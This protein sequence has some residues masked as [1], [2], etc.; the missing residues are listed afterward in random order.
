MKK[1]LL[2]IVVI[3]LLAGGMVAGLLLVQ[4]QQI[5]KQKASNPTG[6]ANVSISPSQQTFQRNT[7]YPV[8]V[9]FNTK[10]VLVSEVDVRLTYS[11]LGV[12]ASN[13]TIS[14]DLLTSGDWN[15][16]VKSV[17][18]TGSTGQIDINCLNS[19]AAGYSNNSDTL[20]AT[21]DLKATQVPIENPLIVSFDPTATVIKQKSDGTD[22]AL[23]PSSTGSY[24]IT[25]TLAG[26]PT[27]SPLVIV[28]SPTASPL[29]GATSSPTPLAT[30]GP[31]ITP[32]PTYTSNP[33]YT[34]VA[35]AGATLPPVPVTGFDAP[36]ILGVAGG[37][38]LLLI[39]VFAL[40]L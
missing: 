17:T 11:N 14:Q 18:S 12:D 36:T 37:G 29:S 35:S 33:I 28:A 34:P 39:G 4:Q 10:G 20:L 9:S 6:T 5:F 13:I 23:T 21:F 22:I 40:I 30:A 27:A 19:A 24:T 31:L 38:I 16:P 2:I 32:T 8:S 26:S 7:S 3:L 15:C 1:Y 25:D